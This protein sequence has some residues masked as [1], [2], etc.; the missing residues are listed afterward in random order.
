MGL[1]IDII[2]NEKQVCGA[3]VPQT[4]IHA[5]VAVGDVRSVRVD[6]EGLNDLFDDNSDVKRRAL[7]C[8]DT[9]RCSR[10]LEGLG[11]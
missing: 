7:D 4:G 1:R 6:E 3:I 11:T 2:G 9:T 10:V 8:F 5:L